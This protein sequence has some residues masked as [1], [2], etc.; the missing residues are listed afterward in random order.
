MM[1]IQDKKKG[2]SKELLIN[3]I[4]S[5]LLIYNRTYAFQLSLAYIENVLVEALAY[6]SLLRFK[7]VSPI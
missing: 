6:S 1:V 2:K 7:C 3:N 5:S 4:N